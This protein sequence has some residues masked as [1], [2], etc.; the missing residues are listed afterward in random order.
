MLHRMADQMAGDLMSYIMENL[1]LINIYLQFTFY[2]LDWF[3]LHSI[4][5]MSIELQASDKPKTNA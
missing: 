5:F 2:L 1:Q 3:H 4:V